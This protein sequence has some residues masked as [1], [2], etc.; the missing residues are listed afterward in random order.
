VG[1]EAVTAIHL[2][3]ARW[4]L[5]ETLFYLLPVKIVLKSQTETVDRPS[6]VPEGRMHTTLGRQKHLI[7]PNRAKVSEPEAVP[8]VTETEMLIVTVGQV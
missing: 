4:V 3:A 6:S 2:Q 7:Q 5:P 8:D 1:K